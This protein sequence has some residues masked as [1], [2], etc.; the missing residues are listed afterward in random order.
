[1]HRIVRR[2]VI[3]L[4]GSDRLAGFLAQ[5]L[6]RD[7]EVFWGFDGRKQPTDP[8]FDDQRSLAHYSRDTVSSPV[9]LPGQKGC[10]ISHFRVL[11]EFAAEEGDPQDLMLVCEDDVRFSPVTRE[12]MTRV[13]AG[14]GPLDI[15]LFC[16]TDAQAD[17]T[18][19]TSHSRRDMQLSL[20]ARPVGPWPHPLSHRFGVFGG[21]MWGAGFYA[22]S[23]DAA[24][25]LT[26]LATREGRLWWLADD[27][28]MFAAQAGIRTQALRPGLVS[29]AGESTMG[30]QDWR[31]T[32]QET[33]AAGAQRSSL[34]ERLALMTR[35]QRARLA[36]VGTRQ[37]LRQRMERGRVAEERVPGHR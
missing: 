19:F 13:L 11:S 31:G 23:R 20:L 29:Y 33:G 37:D 17:F 36:L 1:M 9:L 6:A 10:A 4:E 27:Y 12:V 24:R 15:A 35:L 30:Y 25:R 26:A 5:D 28:K 22:V 2:R 34:R 32:A 21:R 16:E 7:Y 18:P 8:Y 14:E 3:A